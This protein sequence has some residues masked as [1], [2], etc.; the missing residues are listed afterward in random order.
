MAP[1]TLKLNVFAQMWGCPP[2]LICVP[3]CESCK[4]EP[5]CS[6]LPHETNEQLQQ[7]P[8]RGRDDGADQP[9]GRD[10][11]KT[12]HRII[13]ERTDDADDDVA[14]QTATGDAAA[15]EPA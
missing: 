14:V 5:N 13:H 8:D 11:Q 2:Q 7:H 9:A 4:T 1:R 3:P 6:G 15:S 12:E 10:A